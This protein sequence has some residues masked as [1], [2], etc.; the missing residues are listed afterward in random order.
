VINKL[1]EALKKLLRRIFRM[2]SG[3]FTQNNKEVIDEEGNWVGNPILISLSDLLNVSDQTPAPGQ[4]LKWDGDQW[5]PGIDLVGG[6]TGGATTLSELNDV[7]SAAP[8]NGQVLKWNGSL[9]APAVDST[10][11]TSLS[12]S[13]IGD[14]Q[15]VSAT[16][17]ETGQVLKWSGT[18]W[19]PANE[20]SVLKV[21]SDYTGIDSE[22]IQA[23]IDDVFS[24][25][26]GTVLITEGEWD[27]TSQ[28]VV[29][30]GV[31]IEGSG[32]GYKQGATDSISLYGT[33][34][35]VR[36][37][38]GAGA[39]NDYTR[40]AFILNEGAK[41][42]NLAVDYPDQV[43]PSSSTP[44]EYG[45]TFKLFENLQGFIASTGGV[46]S[47]S[48]SVYHSDCDIRDVIIKNG[49]VGVD[50][51]GTSARRNTGDTEYQVANMTAHRFD[52]IKMCVMNYGF[53]F[54]NITDWVF[55]N[56]CEQQPGW[57]SAGSRTPGSS[58]RSYVQEN[59][60]FFEVAGIVDWLKIT[61][62][63]AWAI[64]NALKVNGGPLSS[65][66][67]FIANCSGPITMIGCDF[68]GAKNTVY[69]QGQCYQ[70]N[71][72]MIGC[73]FAPF[74]ANKFYEDFDPVNTAVLDGYWPA[75]V[76]VFDDSVGFDPAT[77]SG[78]VVVIDNNSVVEGISISNSFMFAWARGWVW[79]GFSNKTINRLQLTGNATKI[80]A[81]IINSGT[82]DYVVN[83]GNSGTVEEVIITNN[84]FKGCIK[85]FNP[86]APIDPAD[87]RNIIGSNTFETFG[88]YLPTR[89]VHVKDFGAVGDAVTDD[90]AAIQ[91]AIDYVYTLN[92]I[93]S[94]GTASFLGKTYVSGSRGIGG[95]VVEVS[96]GQYLI[97]SADL[98][99]KEGIHVK[100]PYINPGLQG[101]LDED[102]VSG[103]VNYSINGRY[104]LMD[105]LCINPN[106]SIVLKDQSAISGLVIWP[107][108][109]TTDPS[110][111]YYPADWRFPMYYTQGS[112]STIVLLENGDG[113][114]A[115]TGVFKD[116]GWL[117][118]AI[119][120]NQANDVS[121][122]DCLILGF[123]E[124]IVLRRAHR[125]K[126]Q[127][128]N[129]DCMFCI[130]LSLCYDISRINNVHCW[131]YA[132]NFAGKFSEW[133][134]GRNFMNEPRGIG[135][136]MHNVGDWNKITD[137][138]TYGFMIGY[139]LNSVNNVILHGCGADNR[140]DGQGNL[141][142]NTVGFDIQGPSEDIILSNCQAAAQAHAGIRINIPFYLTARIDNYTAWM[143][144]EH[145]VLI[146]SG[147][148]IANNTTMK[149]VGNGFSVVAGVSPVQD[150]IIHNTIARTTGLLYSIPPG[151]PVTITNSKEF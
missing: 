37:G 89:T 141:I 92:N 112:E 3:F 64:Q 135:I 115:Q 68:D 57:I 131:P 23:A 144:E 10:G 60:V 56:R 25:G 111:S 75:E 91:A 53:R 139:H 26:G 77:D 96:G 67:P 80:D 49:T 29:K 142:P 19:A 62:C 85:E 94:I 147:R 8:S 143:I 16:A 7:S 78:Y 17:P 117:G 31:T 110:Q 113:T 102:V 38:S 104:E 50:A 105:S 151:S 88:T 126:V 122:R 116:G 136:H 71:L 28:I 100:G 36:W 72:K 34:L 63:S 108:N 9:W 20:T 109:A 99:I 58:L 134:D 35:N 32:Y 54:D 148:F 33:V 52:N 73:T 61:D 4:V 47:G 22:K 138:F 76:P 101:S 2:A 93:T 103:G 45:P 59:C 82:A 14:L 13:N 6:G 51:R 95:G 18:T 15:N 48:V 30:N 81:S 137:C 114:P 79:S 106:Y 150:G 43:A 107:S 98:E 46:P 74:N 125:A 24:L 130:R 140:S 40:A 41:V 83:L 132:T 123:K 128:V 133:G 44:T 39:M 120:C 97:N 27:L 1:I 70:L 11:L 119:K 90:T 127:D 21:A 146:S 121:I 84:I 87:T 12:G 5:A 55:V 129:M 118:T 69:I 149:D 86:E 145:A 65:T 124:G 42:K 66:T